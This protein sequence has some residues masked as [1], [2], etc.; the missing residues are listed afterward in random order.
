MKKI[1]YFLL[2]KLKIVPKQNI[3]KGPA[4]L[5]KEKHICL[6]HKAAHTLSL[7]SN[8]SLQQCHLVQ[9]AQTTFPVH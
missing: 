2:Q 6:N 8:Q 3:Q 1:V 7:C 5:G 9:A 4:W